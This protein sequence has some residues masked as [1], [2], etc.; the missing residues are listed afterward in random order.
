MVNE[1]FR[2][3]F[4][5]YCLMKQPDGRYAVLNRHYKPVGMVVPS[6]QH[7]DYA[8]HPCLVKVKGLTPLRARKLSARSE[9]SLDRIYLYNDGCVPTDSQQDWDA[10]SARLQLL[11]K[12]TIAD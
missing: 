2:R 8:A 9:D 3:V 1:S 5:P 7:V 12:L 11:A 4:F 10:Y 6:D